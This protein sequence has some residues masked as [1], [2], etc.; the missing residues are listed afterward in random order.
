MERLSFVAF[1]AAYRRVGM[2]YVVGDNALYW[3][4]Q[5]VTGCKKSESAAR[6]AERVIK[7]WKPDVI[8]TERPEAATRKSDQTKA[9]TAAIANVAADSL[10]IDVVIER[11]HN[12]NNKHEEAVHLVSKYPQLAGLL[13]K[14]RRFFD[15]E[16]RNTVVFEALSL[17][18]SVRNSPTEQLAR[19]MG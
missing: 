1:A 4:I 11:G 18:E 17:I 13:P 3:K 2:V 5:C 16:P 9:M 7:E 6:F 14:P 8:V 12:F 15:P 10:K 19:A